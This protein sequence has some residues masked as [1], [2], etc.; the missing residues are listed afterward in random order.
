M[1]EFPK[2]LMLKNRVSLLLLAVGCWWRWWWRALLCHRP[3]R[4][5]EIEHFL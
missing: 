1:L 3:I 2:S 4:R 5:M